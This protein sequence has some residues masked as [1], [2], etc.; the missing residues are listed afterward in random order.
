MCVC[1]EWRGGTGF[2]TPTDSNDLNKVGGMLFILPAFKMALMAT[3]SFYKNKNIHTAMLSFFPMS[4]FT[5]FSNSTEPS[6]KVCCKLRTGE[7]LHLMFPS[8]SKVESHP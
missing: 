5:F 8:F 6:A 1:V 3:S 4:S 2:Q 7:Q